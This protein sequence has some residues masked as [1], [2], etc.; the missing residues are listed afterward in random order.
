MSVCVLVFLET[1]SP[2]LSEAEDHVEV[3]LNPIH[4]LA[5]ARKMVRILCIVNFP[6]WY[7]GAG[8]Q[9]HPGFY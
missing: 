4:C 5:A 7:L 3:F 8:E 2:N 6:K 9:R 1:D